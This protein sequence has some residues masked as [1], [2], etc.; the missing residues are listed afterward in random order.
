[1]TCVWDAIMRGV[2][3]DQV[4]NDILGNYSSPLEFV[5]SIKKRNILTVGV[6]WQKQPITKQQQKENFEWI[7]NYDENGIQNG[8]LMSTAD[9]F[10]ILLAY[11]LDIEFV[12]NYCGNIITIS[13][14]TNS[15]YTINLTNNSGHMS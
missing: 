15:R 8:H 6:K 11:I 3:R 2:V 4:T 1:M 5:R 12:I 10:L 9:P 13:P 7:K 14:N